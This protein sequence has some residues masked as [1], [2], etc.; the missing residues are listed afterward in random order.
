MILII[1]IILLVIYFIWNNWAVKEHFSFPPLYVSNPFGNEE[2]VNNSGYGEEWYVDPEADG[3][4]RNLLKNYA[5]VNTDDVVLPE[6][7]NFL[8]RKYQMGILNID[9]NFKKNINSSNF[10]E[11]L[12][13]L[14][15]I[16]NENKKID[17]LK[18]N[19]ITWTNRYYE[20][21][22]DKFNI[23]ETP[24]SE[25]F[26]KNNIITTFLSR[27][28]EYQENTLTNEQLIKYGK[29]DYNIYSYKIEKIEKNDLNE[30]IFTLTII[31]FSEGISYAPV[32]YFKGIKTQTDEVKIGNFNMI[33]Y[34]TT[35]K[36]LMPDGKTQDDNYYILND[37]YRNTND[38]ILNQ[39]IF[40]I[41]KKID[42]IKESSKID[43][44][45]VCMT[46]NANDIINPQMDTQ[47]ILPASNKNIC[48]SSFNF[49][50]ERKQ[51][52]VWDTPC[53]EDSDCIFYKSNKNYPN[54]YG[55]CKTNG[56][57]ELPLNMV[58]MGYRYY[59]NTNT[60]RP[61]CYNCDPNKS[62]KPVTK[63]DNCCDKQY[64]RKLYPHLNGPDYVFKDDKLNRDN[65]YNFKQFKINQLSQ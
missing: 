64:D 11:H 65:Y 17:I 63:I 35:D 53:Q 5:I 28:N 61:L 1:L 14:T 34:M 36:L 33:G 18:S 49:Y 44:Q 13:G 24:Y 60:T 37:Y 43:R 4:R 20:Y 55:K 25:E 62:W 56:Y 6:S 32:L 57:C 54:D 7:L 16:T 40:E 22:P 41:N 38:K 29:Q 8:N 12:R 3:V 30:Y 46:T 39:D 26:P 19:L 10:N 47:T 58:N 2:E 23:F 52:G 27:F 48:E 45:Y 42:T 51:T 15:E 31:L 59:L 21:K 9:N 50:G